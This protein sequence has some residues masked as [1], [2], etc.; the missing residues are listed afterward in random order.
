MISSRIKLLTGTALALVIATT[1]F[2]IEFQGRTVGLQLAAAAD[3]DGASAAEQSFT[4]KAMS[5]VS[6]GF[7]KAV[8]AIDI[9]PATDAAKSAFGK[10]M[11][12]IGLDDDS[13]AE[14]DS[15]ASSAAE[16]G[17]NTGSVAVE[18]AR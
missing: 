10:A 14:T 17:Y 13:D 15:D 11:A 5:T 18:T 12:A 8:S 9:T 3:G 16:P 4:E 1:P 2:S 7:D 6:E